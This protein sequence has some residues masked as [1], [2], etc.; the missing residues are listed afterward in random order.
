MPLSPDS[1]LL[2]DEWR[3]QRAINAARARESTERYVAKLVERAPELTPEQIERL[4]ALLASV[5][6]VSGDGEV[7]HA[8]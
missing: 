4:R 7:R 8:A 6:E 2:D 1:P 5:E 3:H